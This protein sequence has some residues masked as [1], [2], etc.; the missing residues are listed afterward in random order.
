MT[1]PT[2]PTDSPRAKGL[3]A[4]FSQIKAQATSALEAGKVLRT[5]APA[6]LKD[7][8]GIAKHEVK[9][10]GIA[11]GKG[12]AVA[13]VGLFFLFLFV[14][15]L[16]ILAY[17]GLSQLMPNWAAALTLVVLFLLIALIAVLVG[18]KMIKSQLPFTPQSALFGLLYDLGVLKE[19]SAMSASRLKKEQ[20]EKA[21]AKRVAKEEA[22]KEAAKNP[23]PAEPAP[24][25]QQLISRTKERREHLKTLRDDLNTYSQ[26][27]Q[28]DA[29]N[30]I[31]D[32]KASAQ[33]LP[34]QAL[35][36][37]KQLASN[38]SKPETLQAHWKS[39]ATLAASLGAIL[40][41]LKKII[42]RK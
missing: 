5:L 3:S 14:I 37:G 26:Q 24:T 7:E 12:A 4:G 32:A 33:K 27:I 8:I 16:V 15:A 41:F 42:G 13:V 19:G 20:A 6:Q 11:L 1:T 9:E 31:G 36:G 39:F 28:A 17:L 10:K 2:E 35:Q 29:Q 38:A 18:V 23:T 25:K 30:L 40:V 21:E 34:S 22:A